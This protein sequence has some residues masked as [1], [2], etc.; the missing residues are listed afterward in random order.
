MLPVVAGLF[1]ASGSIGGCRDISG[2]QDTAWE[3]ELQPL[4]LAQV[5][6][7]AAV[8]SGR[9]RAQTSIQI[10]DAEPDATY[11]WHI[12]SGSC[13]DAGDVIGGSAVYPVLVPDQTG[14]AESD[15]V[16]SSELD[17]EGSFAAWVFLSVS[18]TQDEPNAC[19]AI[20]R[21]R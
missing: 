16:L 9:G 20:V 13:Q 17:P 15:A 8:V 14:T 3:G 10:L 5:R 6:G 12:R 19:G 4:G 11:G 21:L 7:S 2:P 1:V 18:D